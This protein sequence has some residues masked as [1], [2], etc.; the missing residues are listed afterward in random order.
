MHIHILFFWA[1]VYRYVCV[2]S[3]AQ[4]GTPKGPRMGPPQ[5]PPREDRPPDD[6]VYIYIYI[7]VYIYMYIYIHTHKCIHIHIY[8]Y[9][10]KYAYIYIYTYIYIYKYI[11][12]LL[13]HLNAELFRTPPITD[14]TSSK[15]DIEWLYC[16][17][18][19]SA[20][21]GVSPS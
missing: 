5:G 8:I 11:Y 18:E 16:F 15:A 10:H 13:N 14:D 1:C 21:I 2:R 6:A 12:V 4:K 19:L 3:W 7:Y 17:V 9:I 20:L